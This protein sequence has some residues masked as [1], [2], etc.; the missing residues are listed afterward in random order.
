MICSVR[1][2]RREAVPGRKMCDRCA[3]RGL[4]NYYRNKMKH[5]AATDAR[6]ARDREEAFLHY[7]GK[8]SRCGHS[9]LLHLQFHHKNHDGGK[10]RREN[11]RGGNYAQ[12]LRDRGYP[13]DIELLCA[14]CHLEYH[15]TNGFRKY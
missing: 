14:N 2:C 7:G 4:E 9:N 3:A 6:R 8:C 12:V 1:T 15:R 10:D 11:G 5:K 13:D